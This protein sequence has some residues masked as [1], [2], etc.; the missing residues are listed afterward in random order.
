MCGVCGC[1]S[2]SRSRERVKSIL[3]RLHHRGPDD[4]GIWSDA[5]VALGHRRLSIVDLSSAGHQPLVTADGRLITVVN[6]DIYNYP[7]LRRELEQ[8]GA[9]FQ[10]NSDSEVVLHAYRAWGTEAFDCLNGMFAFG[11]W[12]RDRSRLFVVRDRL[13]IKP[14]YYLAESDLFCFSS[15]I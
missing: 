14:V 13:G 15:E 1:L 9:Q 12:D 3:A 5:D 2:P 10:S 11:L 6:G 8:K 4:E 7:A